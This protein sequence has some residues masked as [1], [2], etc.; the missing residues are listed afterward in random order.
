MQ[1]LLLT[2]YERLGS[3]SRV[4]FYQY[5]PYL[6]SQGLQIVKAPFFD[7]E[8]VRRLYAKEAISGGYIFQAYLNRLS[9]LTKSADYDLIWVEK[10]LMPWFPAWF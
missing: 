9:A 4:R 5:L 8:Y 3:S 1:I 10:E 6:E 2:R 7:D